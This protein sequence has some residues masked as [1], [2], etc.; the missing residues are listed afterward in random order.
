[1]PVW[2]TP[3][4]EWIAV[5]GETA[6]V[7]VTAHAAEQLGDVVFVEANPAGTRMTKGAVC[8]VVESTKAA[9]DIY[10]PV[11]GEITE[12]N[13]APAENPALLNEDPEGAG[14][15]FRMRV[16]DPGELDG[17]LDAAAYRALTG[18]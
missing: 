18:A 1:M 7:G 10:A 4:H 11:S 5:E 8:G 12:T 13:P 14:W 15:L 6:T 9:S 3:E 2:Y 17:L 16:S